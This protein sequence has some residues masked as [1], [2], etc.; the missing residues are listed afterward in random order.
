VLSGAL[1]REPPPWDTGGLKPRALRVQHL[2]HSTPTNDLAGWVSVPHSKTIIGPFY[3]ES[4][5]NLGDFFAILAIAGAQIPSSSSKYEN[6]IF[7]ILPLQFSSN[8]ATMLHCEYWNDRISND[9]RP[10]T[11]GN[12]VQRNPA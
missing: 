6:S 5:P 2:A 3:L 1:P 4:K 8:N 11:Y 9:A 10:A 7:L 12:D